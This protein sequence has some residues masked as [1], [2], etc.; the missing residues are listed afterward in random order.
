MI[1]PM[2][3]AEVISIDDIRERR[4]NRARGRTLRLRLAL[5]PHQFAGH[6]LA[7]VERGLTL[8]GCVFAVGLLLLIGAL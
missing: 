1:D 8:S 6:D 5:M 7:D 3:T 2:T 4:D